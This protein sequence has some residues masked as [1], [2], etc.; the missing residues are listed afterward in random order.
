MAL[1]ICN[2]NNFHNISYENLFLKHSDIDYEISILGIKSSNKIRLITTYIKNLIRL[3]E[4]NPYYK[5]FKK[6]IELMQINEKKLSKVSKQPIY[7]IIKRT[8]D[9]ENIKSSNDDI[10]I[11]KQNAFDI[12]NMLIFTNAFN[13]IYGIRISNCCI[14]KINYVEFTK[15]EAI[16]IKIKERKGRMSILKFFNDLRQYI[17]N[18]LNELCS[19]NLLFEYEDLNNVYDHILFPIYP[20]SKIDMNE[21]KKNIDYYKNVI[22]NISL[23]LIKHSN[24]YCPFLY[25]NEIERKK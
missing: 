15:T 11:I 19:K 7:K 12:N 13:D 20:S 3:P 18:E 2:F 5:Y 22:I 17:R 16:I 24:Y 8:D 1:S 23:I 10:K 9:I 14:H 4:N 21:I 25:L 6:E